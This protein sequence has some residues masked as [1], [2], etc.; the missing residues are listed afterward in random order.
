PARPGRAP[1][2][3]ATGPSAPGPTSLE[4]RTVTGTVVDT[5]G[6]PIAGARVWI[7]P[8]LTTGLVEVRTDANGRYRASSLIDVPYSAKAWT[9]VEY[10]GR[11][12]CLRLG[13]PAPADFDSFVPVQG[14]VRDFRWQLTG[15]IED[16]RSLDEHFGGMI[17]VLNAGSF[18]ANG[19]RVE[20]TFTPT[21][22]RIDGSSV[23][24]FTRAIV[25]GPSTDVHDLPVGPYRVTAV[26][27]D[28]GSRRPIGL[29]SDSF[30]QAYDALDVDWTGDGTCSNRAGYDWV[31]VWLHVPS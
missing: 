24:A 11:R 17:R 29:A 21:G 27:L 5:A 20:L 25:V 18:A 22:P 1:S 31:Y 12:L 30:A 28:G 6:R 2:P 7:Q 16:L 26:L 19:A 14:A 9:E 8:S 23:A 3:P 4:P 10:G 15:P 13:M